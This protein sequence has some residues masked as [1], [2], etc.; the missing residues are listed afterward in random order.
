VLD[1][2]AEVGLYHDLAL[3]LRLPIIISDSRE[4]ADLN[5]SAAN[6]QRLQDGAGGQLFTVPFKSPTRS[7]FDWFSVGL[8]YAIFNQRRDSSKP[9][10]VIGADWR[11]A[12]GPRLHAC[13]DGAAVKCPDPATPTNSRD[14][15]ISRGMNGVVAHTTFSKRIGYVEPYVGIKGLLELPQSNSDFGATNDLKGNLLVR[16]P[17]VGTVMTGLEVVPWENRESFQ[18]IAV[19]VRALG[20]YHSPGRDYTELFDALGSSQ[21]GTLRQANPAQFKLGTDGRTSVADQ[22]PTKR[23]FFSGITDQEAYG[24][25]GGSASITWQAGEYVK[26]SAGGGFTYVQPH[27]ITA[28]DACNPDFRG[29][30][31]ASGPCRSQPGQGQQV[32]TGIPNPNYRAVIDSPGRRF[33]V[34]DGTII[35]LF[36]TGVVMF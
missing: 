36:V 25:F 11:T 18:K 34:D 19:D 28:S 2:G 29:D 35:D 31:G 33:V 1:L 7:G 30:L 23:V 12:I 8:A 6:P 15:G 22:D 4:L 27:V 14:P 20:S 26:F 10:W 3:V 21:A 13:N 17:I 16:P 32:V 24:T 9:T 5:G